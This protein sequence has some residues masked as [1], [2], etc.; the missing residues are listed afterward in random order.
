MKWYDRGAKV[1]Q[2]TK[3][4][5][6]ACEN[7]GSMTHQARDCL[8]RPRTKGAKF[9]NK[10]IAADDK[11]EDIKVAGFDAKRDR[12]NGYDAKD[13]EQVIKRHEQLEAIRK[14]MK[15]KEMAEKMYNGEGGED[16]P[17]SEGADDDDTKIREE[18]ATEF[19]EVKKRVRTTAGGSTGSVRNLRIREDT[20]KYL[21]NLDVNSAHYD[22][23]TRS[24]RE[25]PNPDKPAH[26]KTFAGDNFVRKSGDYLA[27]QE[28]QLHALQ[29][30]DKGAD[31][32]AMAAPSLA[33]KMYQQFKAKKES[34]NVQSQEDVLA[35]Y[36][37][38]AEKAPEELALLGGTEKYVEYDRMGRVVKGQE[39]KAKSRYEEDVLVNNHTSVWGSW[40]KD[41]TWGYA[42]CHQAVKNSYCTGKAGDTAKEEVAAQMIANMEARARE[43]DAELQKR[44]EESKL[45]DHKQNIQVW[46]SETA[47]VELDDEKIKA[48]LKKLD[49]QEKEAMEK[50]GSKDK[51]N[52]LAGGEDVTPEEM[53]AWRM[54]R[55]RGDDPVAAGTAGTKG[56]DLL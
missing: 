2:A 27:W 28:L 36:G 37:N 9:T 29:A 44:R 1:F 39:N 7:C 49:R 3:W 22:P 19:G 35:K 14:D 6:G 54:K 42:C 45:K 51:F 56:Y 47:D 26:E 4:R 25:D 48:A 24:M 17:S 38:A 16:G 53:E 12:W 15:Q 13:Y 23:K 41:G 10:N 50:E 40:W 5:K 46:G 34:L 11:V 52:S 32:N 8:E 31:L 30:Y 18:E 33:E 20:A 21:L 43:A 55:A